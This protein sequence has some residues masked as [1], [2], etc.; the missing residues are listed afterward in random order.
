VI[1][2][3][4][5]T[6]T[7]TTPAHAAGA[8]DVVVT[9][10][11]GSDTLTGGFTYHNAP[12]LTS[13]SPNNGPEAGG[14]AVTLTGTDF[15]TVG[16]TTVTFGGA[17]ATSVVVV[18]TTTITC[19]TPAG[20]PG[21][22]DV[23]VTNDFGTDTLLNGF[24]YNA[25]PSVTSVTPADG[26]IAGGTAV[27]I[28]GANFTTTPD[29]TVTFGGTSAT[30]VIVVDSATITCT[31]PAHAAGAVDVV[32][33]NSN[34]SDTLTSGFTYHNAPSL[35]SVSPNNG[36]PAGG[37]AVTLTG[38]DFTTVGT[39]TVTFGGAS[40]TSVVVVNATTITCDTP[41]GTPGAV[42]VVVT[43]D[44]GTDTLLNGFTY[45]NAP[46][47]TSV[48]PADGGIAGGTAVTIAGAN[49][50]TTPDTTVTFGGTAATNMLVVDANT[51]TCDTPAHAA[52]AVDVV[53]TN[54]NGTDTLTNGFTYHNAPTLTSVTP[55]DGSTAGGTAVT[56]TGTDFT[57]AGTTTV[58]FGGASATS[59]VVVNTTTITCD[60]PAGT[61]GA[62][63]VVLTNDFG[64]DTLLGGFTYHNPPTLT[65]VTPNNGT[66]AGGTAVTLTGADFSAIGTTTVT[67]GGTSATSIV[68]VNT[69]TI[70]CATP[71]H[72]AGAVD[73]VVTND[74]GSDT[75]LNGF[76]YNA[77]PSITSVTPSDG[78]VAGGTAVTISGNYFTTTP[79]TTVTFG[80]LA[81][82]NLN[83]VNANTITCDTPAH[84]AG[85]VDVVVTN[86]NGTDTLT[87]GFTYHDPPT[88]TAVFPTDGPVTGGTAVT[89]VGT[90]FTT[91]GTTT[92]TFGGINGTNVLVVNATTITC[93]TPAH[94]AGTF[95]VVVT[96]NFGTDTLVGG[97][98]FHNAPSIISLT[99]DNGPETGGTA[100]TITGTDFTTVGPTTVT[101]GGTSATSI[102]VVNT[103]TITC[104]TPAHT[105]GQV[106]VVVTNDFGTDTLINGY[107]YNSTPS[108]TS[109][110]PADGPVAGGTAVTIAGANFTTTPDTTVTIGGTSATSVI[111]VDANTIT[112]DTPA[113]A[114]GAVDVVVTNSNGSDTLVNGF[115]YHNP[116]TITSVSPSSGPETGGTPV[117]V[118]GTDFTTAGTTTVTF[119]GASATSVVVVDALTIT[120]V[121]PAG[122]LGQVD[123]VVTN[124][125]G[126]DTLVNGFT[127]T[128]APT[129]TSISPADGPVTGGTPVTLT[130][131]NF[132][133]TPDTTVTFDGT[134]ATNLVVLNP[135][136]VTCD[137][138][139]HAAGPVDVTMTNSNGSD[140]LVN[141]F[142][143][144]NPPDVTSV[145]PADGP[146][147][148]A[149]PVTVNG[150]DFTNV[151]TTTVTFGGT[152]ATNVLVVSTTAIT[153]DTPTHA[154]GAVD[155]VVTNDF[156]TDTLVGG[157]TYHNPPTL[158]SVTPDNGP[159]AGGTP[160][161]LTGTDF[162]TAGTTTVT[163]GGTAATN[164]V[165]VDTVT[166]TCDTPVHAPGL[167]DVV[168][169]ND[170][171][172]DTLVG[173][174]T[175]NGEPTLFGVT[176]ANGQVA[177]GTAVTVTGTNFT[178][179][180][181]TTLT[182]DG[183][184]ATNLIVVNSTTI[185][186]DTPA[187]AAGAVD[188]VVTNSNG[189]DTLPGGFTYH[190]P[191]TLTLV[192]PD[193]GSPAGGTAVTLT[194]T[195]FTPVGTT[196]VTFGGTAATN[197]VVVNTTTVTCDTPAHAP[198]LVDVVLT[199]DFGSDTLIGGFT[200]NNAPVVS[201]V[202]PTD[203]PVSGGTAVTIAG[204]N[205]T[206]TPDTTVT[207]GGTSATSVIVVDAN[208]IT[209]TTPAHSAGAV[210][211]TVTNS[212]G[213]DT[214]TGGFT[215]H[216]P[217]SISSISPNTGPL[218]GGTA[219]T[220]FG[221]D[222]TSVGPTTVTFDGLAAANIVVVNLTTITCDT[223][224]HA[225]GAVDVVVTNDFGSDT[226][227]N[228]F[229]YISGPVISGITP[230]DGS[231][232]G[233]T[234]VTITGINFTTT[235][236]TTVTFD[237]T[238]ATNLVVL[239]PTTA[240]CDTPAHAAGTVDVTMTNSNGSDTLTGGFTYHDPPTITFLTPNT[241]PDSGGTPVTVSGSNFT[242]IGTTTV[243]FD[244]TPATNLVVVNTTTIT[245]DTP[246]HAVGP[247]D[248]TVTN[249]FG[250]DTLVNGFTYVVSPPQVTAVTPADGPV[251]GN[252]A[253]TITGNY[254]TTTPDTTVT[255][256]GSSA[257]NMVVVNSSMI[258]C[259][260]PAHSA[261]SVDVVVTNSN[262]SG[263][264]TNGFTY[265]N[266][267]SI[268]L[269]I[270][271]NG[272]VTGGTAVTISGNDFTPVGTT[273][274]T[275]GGTVATNV[276]VVNT[277][278]ITCDTPA[279]SPGQVDV[280]VSNDFG[281]D[282]LVNGY[283]Y[284]DPP[285]VSI[286]TPAD[287]PIAGGTAVTISGNYFTTT[288][289]TTVTF[290][291]TSATN[292][293]V[294]NS[295]T[296]T[297]DTPAHA[298]GP[299]DVTVTN[300]N[301]PGTLP[302]GFTY[303][304]AP[305]VTSLFPDNGPIAGGQAVTISGSDFTSVGTTTVLFDT[306]S[307]TSVVVVDAGTI[308]CVT[309]AHAVGSVD[310]T[311]TNDFGTDTLVNG[312]TYNNPPSLT[313]IT[314]T[315][316]GT[317]G[318]TPVVITGNYFTT[319]PDT[320]V[321]FG[322]TAATN[323]I[324]VDVNTITC[325]TPPH[326]AGT[327]DVT[328]TNSNGSDTLFSAFTYH[329]SPNIVSVTPDNGPAT[330]GTAVT[331]DG[332]DF[333]TFGTTTVTFGAAAATSVVV[334]NANTITCVTPAG[335]PGAVD[336][337]VSNAFG[338]DTLPSGYTYNNPPTITA[339]TPAD[340]GTGGGTAVT[341]SGNDFTTTP[342]TTVTFDV[343]PATSVVVINSTTITCIT[344]AH[345][346]GGVDVTVTNSNGSDTLV[347]GFTYHD[348]PT[349]TA[350]T[351]NSGPTVGGTDV[352]V[353]GTNFTASGTTTVSFGGAA[354]TNVVVLN[355]T[356]LTCDTPAHAAGLVDVVLTNDFGTDTL[357][358]GY[359]YVVVPPTISGVTPTDGPVVGG[360][361]VTITG[362]YFSTTPDTVVT[363]DGFPATNLAV[364]DVNTITCNTPAHSAG[365]VDVTVTNSNGSDTLTGG[366]TY[367]NP[368][369]IALIIP[370][371]GPAFGGA[372]VTISG[373]DFTPVGPTFV[374]FDGLDATNIAIVNSTTITCDTPAH[375]AGAVDVEVM[376]NFGSDILVNG[377]T[378]N[379][380]PTITA[381]NPADGS[382][383][384]GT[385][386]T[387]TGTYFTTSF[388]TTVTFDGAAA[389]NVVVID[390]ST[391]TCDTPAHAAGTV[392][393]TVT[394][395]NGFDT[396][397]GGFTYH[398]PPTLI[399][400]N[401]NTG[402][403]AGGTTVTLTGTDF[404]ALGTTTVTFGGVG[405]TSV[406]VVDPSTITCV[407]PAH[408]QGAVDVTVTND[409]GSDTLINGYTYVNIPPQITSVDPDHGPTAGGQNVTISGQN[410]T[411]APDTTVNF[412]GVPATNIAIPDPNTITCDTPAHAP[413]FVSV[414]VINSNG[415]DL[416]PNA[417]TYHFPPE[418]SSVTP[419][420][421]TSLGGT[422]VT[423]S[424]SLFFNI[425]TTTVTFNSEEA[426]NV[427]V[428]NTT[429]ITCDT[430]AHAAGTVDVTVTNDFGSDTLINGFTFVGGPKITSV[431]PP[432]GLMQGGAPVTIVGSNF[433]TTPDTQVF[434]GIKEAPN[435]AVVNSTTITCD[436][437]EYPIPDKVDVVVTNS[438]G[439]GTL[440]NGFI[441][442][443][444]GG[445]PPQN[446]TDVDTLDLYPYDVVK[447]A[448]IGPPGG[449]YM[450][451]L[452][453]GPGP[454]NS[455]WGV[456]GLTMPIYFAWSGFL[457][458][459]GYQTVPVVMP[460]NTA[461]F[462]NFYTHTLVDNNPPEWAAGG[463]NPNGTGG[464][465]WGLN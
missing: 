128:V 300:T 286:V 66:T 339:V 174:Y 2:V 111:V 94:A 389:T 96:N 122:T 192:T 267:P 26:G 241:G 419:N 457:N 77:G 123:V 180:P 344:P 393:V 427:V 118:T 185:T 351:P 158:T 399:S 58:T 169:T 323:L 456:A 159:E 444:P 396:L 6:I 63:D 60:T 45:N 337:V 311:V 423:I 157:Y 288:P 369:S 429:T 275:F 65:S 112:C 57:T 38:T 141:G 449:L 82:T 445:A 307:A 360:T 386:V 262:G 253:V 353:S 73:V 242:T 88:L 458:S 11:N 5:A 279:H 14:T 381:I 231:T 320:T 211:V 338:S 435:V 29:T 246:A 3:D 355:S 134:A 388:D 37:T 345:S 167:V 151:G 127:Y 239:N 226:L 415:S 343:S 342:D 216:N 417:Y 410:F 259:Q 126:T 115:T 233:G 227:T 121:T 362:D 4:S 139:A 144:H 334:V 206:T 234:A 78:G 425:G 165:I 443:P 48:T 316:G 10:S 33:T 296:I 370:N 113:H 326:A 460:E 304:N 95:D 79:D 53:V 418:I 188:V 258:T 356:T 170:F 152:A 401:P 161:T 59:V 137:T 263:T 131:A 299:V 453:F 200:Y 217:P 461:G 205:F 125:F 42:D 35:T 93:D 327:V 103:T 273:M 312:Y 43:N 160:V 17:S 391:M 117:T 30:S 431:T 330:G 34:G 28:A 177:G 55:T 324:V 99:P 440:K 430:P 368:P 179:T 149:T 450:V 229:T 448:V 426:T 163:F 302:N 32:V 202:S 208:T 354:A 194:G 282:T 71:A 46:S 9:N 25:A 178:T 106:D 18:N 463:N 223:P 271:N 411:T 153:C 315:D 387:L 424:G 69:T 289:D 102:V 143:Y 68:V 240:T 348:S 132:T 251:V 284:N 265:H 459:T 268:A 454:T 61:A 213:S 56:L 201:S 218:G 333:T 428:V 92:V 257:V 50:T 189:T 382:T 138:P 248:V 301:G 219:V 40:A 164:L 150:T 155:V 272:P 383:L 439:T 198:G 16:T 39:T 438:F 332:S 220:I 24:T 376:N 49:F 464:I 12:S 409:F 44:F 314:P 378:Y 186:C 70:T 36:S 295:T 367:H 51:I 402:P 19:D 321:I 293:V 74:F 97:F 406:V 283:T 54:S 392:D 109:V 72:A 215:Y 41:A 276:V 197:V 135:S 291:G 182:F 249:D 437:P 187:H 270:P 256:G 171:G 340:G 175:F 359:T 358:G 379:N 366:Y 105:P 422:P 124:D 148:G 294:L 341:I 222:F 21:A 335:S 203:G 116:P 64:T 264:L 297:C 1:V 357:V 285:L 67:F 374:T 380:P 166:I 277:T 196:T 442:F 207:F 412:G 86:S 204:S 384:G 100:V 89:L 191:P 287:G 420:T 413:G 397:A 107:T 433:T 269:V 365:T 195:E 140:T 346:A 104:D 404:S 91:V 237:G 22:V 317:G 398:N 129:L 15:T 173:G 377:Y 85:A 20:T 350:V 441:F 390:S 101:F 308:T 76:T 142:T 305:S 325:D 408:A 254:F 361:P 394:N 119:G 395:S 181:D 243:T 225:A 278:T 209:C 156:G 87:N 385:N 306:G 318:G 238:P 13:V 347:G 432:F 247:V 84:A 416:L 451:F 405:A 336:V 400:V 375:A 261:G 363:F 298:A 228:G 83:V 436:T 23:V 224:A 310:V 232:A 81:A 62:V 407:T 221:F 154:A 110:T 250:S 199:N 280:V 328:V 266:P 146:V 455:P 75:L 421:G 120:C 403:D 7:C 290:D 47:I 236:D 252:T 255:F 331:I 183:I 214:L 133:T 372:N 414:E 319:A 303:H 371:N 108:I 452:S 130:G 31:T 322:G 446:L 27:T 462:I 274:V 184:A 90:N 281:L 98:T 245:C 447:H 235:P 162:T 309:P 230:T 373:N 136:T 434:F 292:V 80:G 260:T 364:V 465:K 244:T 212:N 210:D 52:G 8:V 147:A 190:N 329:D 313:G 114:A 176:P 193:N 168:V 352:T 145:T 172:T 349:I